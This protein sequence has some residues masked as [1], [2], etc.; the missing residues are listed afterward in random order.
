MHGDKANYLRI[1]LEDALGQIQNFR[2]ESQR[3]KAK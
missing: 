3:A 1:L 2:A